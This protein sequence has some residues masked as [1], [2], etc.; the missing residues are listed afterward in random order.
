MG[1]ISRVSSRTYRSE[2]TYDEVITIEHGLH[3]LVQGTVYHCP[4]RLNGLLNQ[5]N[6]LGWKVQLKAVNDM[7]MVKIIICDQ[8]VYH[9]K[10]YLKTADFNTDGELDP[11]VKDAVQQIQK[12]TSIM[13]L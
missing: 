12:A 4:N 1:L 9:C 2:M 7:E 13:E 8:V 11:I 3:T 5:L 6:K 10:D